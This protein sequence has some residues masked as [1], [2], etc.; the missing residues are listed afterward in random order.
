[1]VLA[2][3]RDSNDAESAINKLKDNGYNPKDISIIMKDKQEASEL[4]DSTGVNK[5]AAAEGATSG[6]LTGGAL[7]ALTG[8]LVGVGALAI[9]GLGPLLV[10]GPIASALG[11]AGTTAGATLSGG[12]L[13]ALTGGL[14]GGLVGMGVPEEDAKRYEET[15]QSGGV[16][17]AVPADS[18]NDNEI[19]SVLQSCQADQIRNVSMN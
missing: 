15:I 4:A 10:A 12:A 3:F 13:G 14:V 6:A 8:L 1:M 18:D 19:K 16:L 5:S 17:V 2:A 11:L 9:P 7:G